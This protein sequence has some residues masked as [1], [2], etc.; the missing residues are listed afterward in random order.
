MSSP[1]ITIIKGASSSVEDSDPGR[2][3]SFE[4][5]KR[6]FFAGKFWPHLFRYN[7]ARLVTYRLALLPKPFLT[8]LLLRL[9]SHG[10]CYF[11]DQ[12]GGR[13]KIGAA[14]WLLLSRRL[15]QDSFRKPT[16]L[17]SIRK[18]VE[19]LS[20]HRIEETLVTPRLDLE[21]SPVYLRTDLSFGVISGGSVGHIAGVLNQLERFAKSPIF[22]TTDPIPMVSPTV[23]SHTVKL[24][25]SFW[26]FRELPSFHINEIIFKQALHALANR[27]LSF[28]YQRYS[29]N[30]FVGM[31]LA[32]AICNPFCPR[33]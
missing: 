32:N 14:Q 9:L 29:L 21:A 19:L 23:E 8:A 7:P 3:T 24:D 12:L 31:K 22:L 5:I 1:S 25:A 20:R 30:N 27:R 26:N 28:V 6:C 17:R 2:V 33:I 13:E 4:E 10:E 16:L 11:E 18:D 15:L